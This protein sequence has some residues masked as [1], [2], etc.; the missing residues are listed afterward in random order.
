MFWNCDKYCIIN[1]R[2]VIFKELKFNLAT[3]I[4]RAF[5][6]ALL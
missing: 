4:K 5:S 3:L 1:S 2:V 6:L